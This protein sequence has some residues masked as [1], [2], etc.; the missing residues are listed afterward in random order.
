[1]V[2]DLLESLPRWENDVFGNYEFRGHRI[3]GLDVVEV[4]GSAIVFRSVSFVT[5]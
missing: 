2:S 3:E 4:D 1:V 5:L